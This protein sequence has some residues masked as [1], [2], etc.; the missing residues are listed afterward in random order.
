MGM[1]N[2]L[3]KQVEWLLKWIL[4]ILFWIKTSYLIFSASDQFAINIQTVDITVQEASQG[5][6]A[7][8]SH[9]RS[10]EKF[11]HFYDHVLRTLLQSPLFPEE[12]GSP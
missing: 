2:M 6:K 9:M 3:L 1:M 5:A 11:D 12:R 10:E 4:L 8:A 7:L